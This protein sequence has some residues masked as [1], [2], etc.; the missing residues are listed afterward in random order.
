VEE[1]LQKEQGRG[2]VGY[3]PGGSVPYVP[4]GNSLH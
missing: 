2:M 3:T 1:R 4:F